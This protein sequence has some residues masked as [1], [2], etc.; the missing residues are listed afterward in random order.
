M[1]SD[2]AHEHEID[3]N[4]SA[5]TVPLLQDSKNEPELNAESLGLCK[6]LSKSLMTVLPLLGNRSFTLIRNFMSGFMLS[7]Q[8]LDTL[9][10]S[11]LINIGQDIVF[12]GFTSPLVSVTSIA[13]KCYGT[14]EEMKKNDRYSPN[15]IE[16]KEIE[17][18]IIFKQGQLLAIKIAIISVFPIITMWYGEP[19]L[20]MAGYPEPIP[21]MAQD[22][23]RASVWGVPANALYVNSQQFAMGVQSNSLIL[24]MGFIGCVSLVGSGYVLIFGKFGF[25]EMGVQGLGYAITIRSWLN[26][27]LITLALCCGKKYKPYKLFDSFFS[28]EASISKNLWAQ[29]WPSALQFNGELC[30]ILLTNMMVGSLGTAALTARS[31]STQYE[32]LFIAPIFSL[33]QAASSLV[34]AALGKASV[35]GNFNDIRRFGD[36]QVV[37]GLILSSLILGSFFLFKREYISFYLDVNNVEN[38][39]VVSLLNNYLL[40]TT[41]GYILDSVKNISAGALRGIQD[42]KFAST[43]NILSI[44]FINLPLA[45]LF[46][47]VFKWELNGL[48]VANNIG[49]TLSAVILFSRWR[50]KTNEMIKKPNSVEAMNEFSAPAKQ[51][52]WC[53]FFKCCRAPKEIKSSLPDERR[54]SINNLSS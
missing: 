33:A 8:G 37:I 15:E 29:G 27:L 14:A 54:P 10:A 44:L 43:S 31:V 26:L 6:I 16:E 12:L 50:F 25:P 30:T 19:L 40:L 46:R 21:R 9:A 53:A 23:F 24:G 52:S 38:Q 45:C 47:Y 18:G 13:G 20:K 17:L 32:L 7:R 28:N 35:N 3:F 2:S 49:M 39:P 48:A 42:A 34:S 11:A 41:A 1:K 4:K 51:K 22:F 36:A 5:P